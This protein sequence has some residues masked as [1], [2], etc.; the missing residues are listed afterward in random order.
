EEVAHL[1]ARRHRRTLASQQLQS[2]TWHKTPRV[3]PRAVE[4]EQP[5]PR[6]SRLR[7]AKKRLGL[8]VRRQLCASVRREW[9]D[10]RQLVERLRCLL[11]FEARADAGDPPASLASEN[12]KQPQAAGAVLLIGRIGE[13]LSGSD[14]PREMDARPDILTDGI[15]D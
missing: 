12:G 10:R 14:A 9:I 2:D 13:V 11:I 3:F 7:S 8:E 6:K 1:E 5:R 15:Q 4:V